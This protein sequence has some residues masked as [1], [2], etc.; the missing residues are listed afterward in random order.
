MAK[1]KTE[2][3]KVIEQLVEARDIIF[4]QIVN[5]AMSGE[6]L[7]ITNTF[8]IGENYTFVLSHFEDIEDLS[9]RK[10]VQLCKKIEKTIYTIMNLNGIKENEINL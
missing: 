9:V 7:H 3:I 5:L 1:D 8:N 2:I 10:L 6:M 4:T